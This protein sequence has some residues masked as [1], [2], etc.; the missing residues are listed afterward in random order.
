MTS[1]Q[2]WANVY[3]EADYQAP[4]LPAVEQLPRGVTR[5]E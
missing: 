4:Y 1:P 2:G 5:H 3:P